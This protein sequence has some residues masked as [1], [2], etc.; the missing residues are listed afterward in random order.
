MCQEQH[1]IPQEGAEGFPKDF[2]IKSFM[3]MKKID[4]NE[5]FEPAV[6]CEYHPT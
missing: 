4:G 6:M 3:E 5:R 2:R 1:K